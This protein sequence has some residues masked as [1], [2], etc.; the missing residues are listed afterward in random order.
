MN[1]TKCNKITVGLLMIVALMSCMSCTTNRND[2]E[3]SWLQDNKI[4][5]NVTTVIDSIYIAEEKFGEPYKVG[6]GRVD[7]Y[8]L[9]ND[10]NVVEHTVFDYK[11]EIESMTKQI[12]NGKEL[13]ERCDY[14]S[15]GKLAY[16]IKYTYMD[17]K[18]AE[19]FIT[20]LDSGQEQL[21]KYFYNADNRFDSVVS[22]INDVRTVAKFSWTDDK[23][24]TRT[25]INPDQT[26]EVETY[27]YDSDGNIV[28]TVT[29]RDTC[30]YTYLDNGLLDRLS[31]SNTVC[32][33]KYK[34][35]HED[36]W[37]EQIQYCKL[38]DEEPSITLTSRTYTYKKSLL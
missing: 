23:C 3:K 18:V 2:Q 4:K 30:T 1:Q 19:E 5:G 22:T 12:W 32:S 36:N 24:C 21:V 8:V 27:Y 25:V 15:D 7:K 13:Q 9:N 14:K 17:G 35:D 26:E 6:L 33:Y 31:S 11:G 38:K 10:G 20:A 16:S 34:Y 29:Q 37:I 28:K